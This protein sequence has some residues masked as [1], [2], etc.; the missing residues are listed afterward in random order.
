MIFAGA[1]A[2]ARASFFLSSIFWGTG[3]DVIQ[4]FVS[5]SGCLHHTSWPKLTTRVEIAS[6]PPT[7]PATCFSCAKVIPG[8]DLLRVAQADLEERR[9]RIEEADRVW[10]AFLGDRGST[11]GHVMYLRRVFRMCFLFGLIITPIP[12]Y[13]D[14]T[15]HYPNRTPPIP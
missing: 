8:S 13:S 5:Y 9:G 10:K 14:H 6:L 1:S 3:T 2:L 15:A 4:V 7:P 12:S 11:T